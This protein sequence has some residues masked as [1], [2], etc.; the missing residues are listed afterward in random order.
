MGLRIYLKLFS[1]NSFSM[2]VECAQFAAQTSESWAAED[3]ALVEASET[4][5]RP[6]TSLTM[7]VRFMLYIR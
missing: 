2:G 3:D 6:I 4:P 7:L 1:A 5:E